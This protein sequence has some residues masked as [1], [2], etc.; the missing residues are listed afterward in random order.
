MAHL[1]S[2][3]CRDQVFLLLYEPQSAELLYGLLVDPQFTM[4]LKQRIIKL[5]A[6]LLR[7]DRVYEIYKARLRL[8]DGSV[9]SSSAGM[10][11]GLVSLLSQQ[12]L[13]ME[14]VAMLLNQFLSSGE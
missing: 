9:I 6:Q 5:L 11:T 4:E 3:T 1:D 12:P 8:Q 2:K 7:S 13:T 14:V 10:A